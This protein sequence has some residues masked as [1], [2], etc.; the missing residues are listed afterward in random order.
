MDFSKI[1]M[2][3]FGRHL[4]SKILKA[5]ASDGNYTDVMKAMEAKNSQ[6]TDESFPPDEHSLI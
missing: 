5:T 4:F 1:D 3:E 2:G 6:Y